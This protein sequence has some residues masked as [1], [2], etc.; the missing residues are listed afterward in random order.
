MPGIGAVVVTLPLDD[1]LPPLKD[2]DGLLLLDDDPPLNEDDGLLLL[3]EDELPPL[4]DDRP[5]PLLEDEEDAAGLLLDELPP[6][7][8]ER[9]LLDDDELPPEK[10]DRPPPFCARASEPLRRHSTPASA[11][12]LIHLN[13]VRVL[14][15]D[16]PGIP[17]I[18]TSA[19]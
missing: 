16:G 4:N 11:S 18:D 15:L 1:E 7:N 5:L 3:E 14:S 9:P 13:I 10:D 2:E 19:R 8:D 17:F 12:V 6:L